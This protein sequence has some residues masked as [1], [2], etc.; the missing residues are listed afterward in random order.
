MPDL[1]PDVTTL[2]V[3][4]Q[5]NSDGF[6]PG[7]GNPVTVDEVRDIYADPKLSVQARKDALSALRQ[8][9]VGRNSADVEEGFDAVINEIDRGLSILSQPAEG[10]VDGDVAALRD[11]AVNPDNL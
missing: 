8:E 11:T 3:D 9:M 2:A 1:N 10:Q 6:A 4:T 7:L 5:I